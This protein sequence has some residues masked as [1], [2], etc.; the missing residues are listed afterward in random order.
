MSPA[1]TLV[2]DVRRPP[3]AATDAPT[4]PLQHAA[5][6]PRARPSVAPSVLLFAA[7]AAFAA[8]HVSGLLRARGEALAGA[9]ARV[10][11]AAAVAATGGWVLARSAGLRLNRAPAA[12][13]RC[14]VILATALACGAAAGTPT[15]LLAPDRLPELA[16]GLARGFEGIRTVRWPYQGTDPWV[17][18]AVLLPVA[19]VLAL[20]AALCFWPARRGAAALHA[21]AAGVLVA[22]FA[23]GVV[24]HDP[25][26]GLARGALL[27]VLLAAWAWL[28]RA[29]IREAAPAALA[30]GAAAVLALPLAAG[31]DPGRPLLEYK[32]W[33]ADAAGTRFEWDHRYGPIDWPRTGATLLHVR[34]PR[35]HYWKVETLDAFDGVRWRRSGAPP[36]PAG[37]Y[38]LPPDPDPRFFERIEV[39]IRSLRSDL[40]VGAGTTLGVTGAG[41]TARSADGTVRLT[42]DRLEEGDS[43]TAATYVPDPSVERLRDAPRVLPPEM[44]AYTALTLPPGTAAP[45]GAPAPPG[46]AAPPGG[47]VVTAGLRGRSD[48]LDPAVAERWRAS[49]YAGVHRLAARLAPSGVS[50]YEAVRSIESHLRNQYAYTERPPR[51]RHPL[52]S[53]LLADR[54][55]YCQQFSGAMALMLRMRGIPAR[56]AGGFTPG[57]LD[58]DTGE[59]RVRDLDAHSWVEVFFPDIG[60][61]PFDPTPAASPAEAQSAPDVS[62]SAASGGTSDS[63]GGRTPADAGGTFTGAEGPSPDAPAPDRSGVA[64]NAAWWVAAPAGLALLAVLA[65]RAVATA[66]RRSRSSALDP[67]LRDLESAL[68]RLD[69]PPA[70]GVTLSD[71]E[72]RFRAAGQT[73]AARYARALRE[74][75]FGARGGTAPSRAEARAVRRELRRG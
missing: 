1:G 59:H 40:A 12:A 25:G 21:A 62:P 63:G 24:E 54:R 37:R 69:D 4:P 18:L 27:L 73:R 22:L 13:A 11:L 53:F 48:G 68:A 33:S 6:G 16:D 67:E 52:A 65:G 8:L 58:R 29:Q 41:A 26:G 71:L 38:E 7:L 51:R 2:R 34:A 23:V 74:R 46:A 66:R 30:V 57:T 75:R 15:A 61:V 42:G 60:W 45:D 17:E 43:Y 50:T 31:L 36:G 32:T 9:D 70:P 3:T 14:G 39:T 55:G 35:S 72:R 5:P 64:L 19:L 47:Q 49:P 10:L 28:P 56:V 20:A 44:G